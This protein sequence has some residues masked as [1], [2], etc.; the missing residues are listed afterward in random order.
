MDGE[1]KSGEKKRA[2]ECTDRQ[3]IDVRSD[4]SGNAGRERERVV[5]CTRENALHRRCLL[6]NEK[7]QGTVLLARATS[8]EASRF[9]H[10]E[11]QTDN[12]AHALAYCGHWR[13]EESTGHL[14]C[15]VY[16]HATEGDANE[17]S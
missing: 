1:N 6:S 4:T 7:T 12:R 9:G 14:Q 13:G 11:S 2:G 16:G 17:M 10:E 15:R 5:Y 8:T 3:T